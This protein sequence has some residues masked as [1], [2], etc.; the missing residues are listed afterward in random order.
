MS[1]SDIYYQREGGHTF[2]HIEVD[3]H[4]TVG[5][6]KAHLKEKH[7]IATDVLLFVEDIEEPFGDEVL[8][9]VLV[10][11]H[12]HGKVHIHGCHHVEVSVTFNNETV[13]HTF[14]PGATVGRVKHW[15][16]EKKFHMTAD[17]A[18]E[19]VLQIRGTT[20]RPSTGTHIG[21]LTKNPTCKIA[22]D[23]VAAERIQGASGEL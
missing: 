9:E 8:I 14:A 19:H 22:F 13:H 20:E 23:L 4:I 17:D 18:G 1:Q 10:T 5:V 7:R 2:E 15:A 11:S 21:A 3:P 6:L 12:H 16:A